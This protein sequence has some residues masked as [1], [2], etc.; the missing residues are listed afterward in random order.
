MSDLTKLIADLPP[1]QVNAQAFG[2]RALQAESGLS[3]QRPYL[4][5]VGVISLVPDPWDYPWRQSRHRILSLMSRYFNVIWCNP[6]H[7]WRKWWLTS[8]HENQGVYLNDD[9]SPGFTVYQPERWLPEFGRP[10]SL[11]HWTLQQRLRRAKQ[12][13]TARGCNTIILDLWRPRFEPALDLIDYDLSSYHIDDEYTFSETEKPTQDCEARILSR[14]D[15][16]FI[17][18]RALMEKKGKL[19][20]HTTFVPNGVDC[21]AYT[22]S[23]G[24]PAELSSIPH[25]RIGYV[26]IIKHQLDFDLLT[27]LARRHRQWSFVLVGPLKYVTP[28]PIQELSRMPNVYFLGGKPAAVLPA[29]TQH[30]DVCLLC[31]KIDGYTKFIYPLKLHEYLASGRPVVGSPLPCLQ[32]FADLIKIAETVDEWSQALEESLAPTASFTV[33]VNSRRNVASRYDWETLVRLIVHTLC[34]RLGPS[35]LER[36][37]KIPSNSVPYHW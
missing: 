35:Y 29:Y 19:N 22:A 2:D 17:H 8:A 27:A 3:S 21:R 9:R 7:G 20:P 32:E 10:S 5:D 36:F 23:Y 26:G 13:L 25:P 1:E 24:E 16:V 6:A 4:P 31:Y 28:L 34:D 18:S 12:T 14:A 33:Q 30:L 37:G 15:Q 11:A